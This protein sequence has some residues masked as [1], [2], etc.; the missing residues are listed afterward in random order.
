MRT[1]ARPPDERAALGGHTGRRAAPPESPESAPPDAGVEGNRRLTSVTGVVLLV[2]L[3]VQG[4]TVLR[5]ERLLS[6]HV[7]VGV[8]LV[9]PV[10]LKAASTTYRFVRYHRGHRA[11]R[12]SGPPHAVLRLIG[13][14][15]I[16]ST[17]ALLGS[18]IALIIAGPA[19]RQPFLRLHQA[20]FLLWFALMTIH[21][22]GHVAGALRSTRD[23]VRDSRHEPTGRLRLLRMAVIAAALVVGVGLAATLLPRAAQWKQDDGRAGGPVKLHHPAS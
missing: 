9:G 6:V 22:L 21:V 8:L 2:L 15:V 4:V 7:F 16:A 11:Y 19:H 17:L 13:P 12:D 20:S 23:E 3:A 14:L 5:V 1:A 18:G 10:L